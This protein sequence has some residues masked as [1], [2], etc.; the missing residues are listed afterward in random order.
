VA[1]PLVLIGPMGA[2]KSTLGRKLAKLLETKFLDTDRMISASHGSIPKIFEDQ[3]EARFRTLETVA[4][5]KA[6]KSPAVIATGGG[7]VV[8]KKNREL[9]QDMP[10]IFLDTN[11]EWV[12]SRINLDKRPLLKSNPSMWEKLY[13][14]RLG[15]YQQLATATVVTANRPIRVV[16]E[17]LESKARDVL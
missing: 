3:G 15:Y 16:L 1:K 11:A 13:K 5:E 10:T 17:E 9:L 14:E 8:T 2:G 12:L 7:V 4:L 6:L